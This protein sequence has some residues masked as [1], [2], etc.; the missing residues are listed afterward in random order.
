[1]DGIRR[2]FWRMHDDTRKTLKTD[3]SDLP[4][5]VLGGTDIEGQE[6]DD[7]SEGSWEKN[8]GPKERP[9]TMRQRIGLFLGPVL[10]L[11]LLL[12][13]TPGGMSVAAQRTLA[14][15]SLMCTWWVGY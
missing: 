12:I 2:A 1:M 5:E 11:V 8:D 13:P 10:F 3:F 14:I 9:Y 7:R 4:S 15:T 6:G